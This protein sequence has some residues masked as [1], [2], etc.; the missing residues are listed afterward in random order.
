[1]NIYKVLKFIK[2]LAYRL[3]LIAFF[4]VIVFPFYFMIIISLKRE[5]DINIIPVKYY[6]SPATFQNYVSAWN[7]SKFALYFVNTVVVSLLT[8][9]IVSVI[10]LMSGYALSRYQFKGKSTA[11]M[12]FLISQM[13]PAALM[14]VPL[15]TI[16]QKLGLLNTLFSV[17]L[18]TSANLLAYCSILM[19]GFFS[20]I[21]VQLEQAAWIDGCSKL[22]AVIYV[23]LPLVMPGL[24]ATG[25]YA[26]VNAWNIFLYPLILLTNPD[27][28][29]LTLGLK[30][31][32]GQYTINYGRLSAAGVICLIPAILMFSYIQKHIV[33]G[34]S[35]GAIKG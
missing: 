29:T 7:D 18:T 13:V 4:I 23:I 33:V 35:A 22:Q 26:F 32:I 14:I 20:N 11:M 5:Q 19:K 2:S 31:L 28:F 3:T 25:A 15:F 24:V 8:L 12:L 30:S 16:I 9:V 6:P 10:S 1:M 34:L 21:S 17:A 27:K